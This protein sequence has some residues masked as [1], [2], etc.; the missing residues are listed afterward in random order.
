MDGPRFESYRAQLGS[1]FTVRRRPVL[2][3]A[4]PEA[5]VHGKAINFCIGS[6]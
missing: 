3:V 6:G 5:R 2:F 1:V 4:T